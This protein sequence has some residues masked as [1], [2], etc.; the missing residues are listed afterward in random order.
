M[1]EEEASVL[2]VLPVGSTGVASLLSC[3]SSSPSSPASSTMLWWDNRVVGGASMM[4]DSGGTPT[5]FLDGAGGRLLLPT[6]LEAGESSPSTVVVGSEDMEARRLRVAHG[7]CYQIDGPEGR[8]FYGP[9]RRRN[10]L[11]PSVA[12]KCH[13]N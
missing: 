2:L 1:G 12:S 8:R 13:Q 4:G 10:G 3:P 9:R 6:L 5:A 7:V 11:P